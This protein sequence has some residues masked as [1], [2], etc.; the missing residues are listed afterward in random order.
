MG[1]IK[2]M[3]TVQLIAS[4]VIS[5]EHDALEWRVFGSLLVGGV[6]SG[7]FGM[8]IQAI[9]TK[10]KDLDWSWFATRF[11]VNLVGSL[12][13]GALAVWI[14]WH[15]GAINPG[16]LLCVGSSFICGLLA[17]GCWS[18][19]EGRIQQR[20]ADAVDK[21]IDV[22]A[23]DSRKKNGTHPSE[24]KGPLVATFPPR[25]DTHQ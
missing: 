15:Y 22:I 6:L 20:A 14:I 23:P 5:S 18:V 13:F 24:E 17:V 16:P 21:L 25:K 11:L 1:V 8:G 7:A 4:A 12:G 19:I 2:L 10:A 9:K 3:A